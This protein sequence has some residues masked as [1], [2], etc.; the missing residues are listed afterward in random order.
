MNRLLL[1]WKT[2]TTIYLFKD[3][4]RLILWSLLE[5]NKKDTLIL[6]VGEKKEISIKKVATLI[7]EKM[8]YKEK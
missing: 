3:L 5:Y 2:I 6:S 1:V 4:A 7:A 8:N